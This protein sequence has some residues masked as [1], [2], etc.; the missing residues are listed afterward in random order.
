METGEI[1]AYRARQQD[2]LA[3]VEILKIGTSQRPLRRAG[4]E[5]GVPAP[6]YS[7]CSR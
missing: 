7:P 4:D 1:W 2:P 5:R 3:E 6:T